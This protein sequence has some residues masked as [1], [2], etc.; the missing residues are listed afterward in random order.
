[1]AVREAQEVFSSLARR[2]LASMA[3][4]RD[5]LTYYWPAYSSAKA[6]SAVDQAAFSS[7]S[8]FFNSS[9]KAANP[10]TSQSQERY[11]RLEAVKE[12]RVSSRSAS[13][14]FRPFKKAA[15]RRTE[16]LAST[17]E[18]IVEPIPPVGG[19]VELASAGEGTYKMASDWSARFDCPPSED[20]LQIV[21]PSVCRLIYSS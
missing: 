7:N 12:E 11:H 10:E 13:T 14:S 9:I 2:V 4:W 18:W 1:M 20:F 21:I 15:T 8:I 3:L 16:S 19:G 17:V 5:C 6:R